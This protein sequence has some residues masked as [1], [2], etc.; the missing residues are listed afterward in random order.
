[1]VEVVVVH[2]LAHAVRENKAVVFPSGSLQ[3]LLVL[4]LTMEPEG[5]HGLTSQL[6]RA[7]ALVPL[8]R[9]EGAVSVER[10]LHRERTSVEVNVGPLQT[11]QLTL[12]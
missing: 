8:R 12:S 1:V 3:A 6:H 10:T 7:A 9:I 4:A 2:R 5:F 11:Q